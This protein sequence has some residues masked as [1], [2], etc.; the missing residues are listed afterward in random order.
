MNLRTLRYVAR[1]REGMS[2]WTLRQVKREPFYSNGKARIKHLSIL[3]QMYENLALETICS[4]EWVVIQWLAWKLSVF[5]LHREDRINQ[6]IQA[7]TLNLLEV[8][9]LQ[10]NRLSQDRTQQLR[11]RL[12]Q[13]QL[14]RNRLLQT[15][16][17][18]LQPRH[19]LREKRKK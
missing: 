19:Q 18:S 17:K 1:A 14:L 6:A 2:Q 10:Q 12:L 7:L 8:I 15:L 16:L 5:H 3:A 11:N 9:R 13:T 4:V